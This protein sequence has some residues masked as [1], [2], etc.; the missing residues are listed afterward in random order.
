MMKLNTRDS[1]VFFILL[2]CSAV[3][4]FYLAEPIGVLYINLFLSVQSCNFCALIGL[5]CVFMFFMFFMT[6]LFI[7]KVAKSLYLG[8]LALGILAEICFGFSI[9]QFL[10]S[11]VFATLGYLLAWFIRKLFFYF[12]DKISLSNERGNRNIKGSD[13]SCW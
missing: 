5:P 2:I 8:I 6:P 13:W 4:S 12:L 7:K 10:F 1:F 3:F 9:S 11:F